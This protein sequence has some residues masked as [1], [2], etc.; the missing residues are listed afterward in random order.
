[1]G[2]KS[3]I[4]ESGKASHKGNVRLTNE[5]TLLTLESF[6]GKESGVDFAGLYAIADGLGGNDDGEIASELAIRALSEHLLKFIARPDW[7]GDSILTNNDLLMKL[8]SQAIHYA[9]FQVLT[10]SKY[11]GNR[12]GTTLTAM[13]VFGRQVYIAN[14]GDSRLYLFRENSIQQLTE[15]HSLVANLVLAGKI[16]RNEIYNHPQRNVIT[17]CLGQ[18]EDL[19]IDLNSMEIYPGDTFFLCSDGLWEMVR[20]DEIKEILQKYHNPKWACRKLVQAANK[21]GGVD[22]I[23]IIVVNALVQNNN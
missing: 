12:M 5:D 10:Q 1:M 21:N 14:V 6:V 8:L 9:N 11:K 23:S 19:E 16:G 2:K 4:I 3:L 13:L 15:D 7:T 22:N 20:D 17:K 18:R